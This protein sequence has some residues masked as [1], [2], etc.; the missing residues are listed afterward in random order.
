MTIVSNPVLVRELRGRM[1]GYRAMIIQTAYLAITSVATLLVYVAFAGDVSTSNQL[2]TSR[3]IGKA[4]FFTV[5]IVALAQVSIITQSLTAGSIAGE[6]E[7]Q[8]YDLLV[9]T[10]LTPWQIVVG[11]LVSALAFASLLV[12]SVLPLAGLSFLFGGVSATELTVAMFSLLIT[13]LL[14]ASIGLFWSTVMR[15][16]LGATIM[17][18]ATILLPLLGIPFLFF[19]LATFASGTGVFDKIENEPVFIYFV[20]AILCV[21]PFIALGLTEA[22]LLEDKNPFFFVLDPGFMDILVPSPWLAYTFISL[23]FTTLFLFLSTHM[24][25]PVDYGLSRKEPRSGGG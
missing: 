13:A 22:A 17:A 3:E 10:L 5:V 7:R 14:Y 25:K 18:Q 15:S 1:R 19:I 9:T 12:M 20:G 24:L 16:T 11:K 4:I 2:E 8:S 23:L 6:K 21:H